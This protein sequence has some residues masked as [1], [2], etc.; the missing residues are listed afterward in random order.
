ME[1]IFP[2]RGCRADRF[3]RG[4][5]KSFKSASVVSNVSTVEIGE[6]VDGIFWFCKQPGGGACY[7]HKYVPSSGSI[8]SS[9]SREGWL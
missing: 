9:S 5:S 3:S 2:E 7:H 8:K 4:S 1:P 6:L